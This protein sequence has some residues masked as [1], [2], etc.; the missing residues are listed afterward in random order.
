MR[1]KYIYISSVATIL[2]ASNI[3]AY[4]L[5]Q[6][7]TQE[8]V[9]NNQVRYIDNKLKNQQNNQKTKTMEQINAEEGISAEQIVVKITD[10]GYVTSHGDHFHFY[11][12]KVPFDAI[13]S[14]ELVMKDSNYQFNEAHV[15]NNI[16]DGYIIKVDGK[17]YA[18]LKPNSVQKNIRSKAEIEEQVA[19]GTR[20]AKEKSNNKV[21]STN[22][23]KNRN[24]SKQTHFRQ[25]SH[26]GRYTTDDGYVFNP[27]DVIDDFGDAYLVPHG[28]HFHYIPKKDLSP[29][30]LAA[31]QNFWM[32]KS[33]KENSQIFHNATL[34]GP[35]ISNNTNSIHNQLSIHTSSPESNSY[36][37]K[38]FNELLTQ[39][40]SQSLDQRHTEEDG[41]VFEPTQVTGVNNFG[42]II[43]HGDHF[44]IIPHHKLSALEITLA[45]RHLA[46]RPNISSIP[47]P[48]VSHSISQNMPLPQAPSK[49]K[50]HYL[51]NREITPYGQGLDGRTYTTSD[52]YQ[53]NK[54]SILSVDKLGITVKH[55]DHLHYIGLGELEQSELNHVNEWLKEN[56]EVGFTP[57]VSNPK[58]ILLK[59]KFDISKVTRKK[60]HNG[61]IGYILTINNKEYYYDRGELDLT[62]IAF[63]EQELM[64]KNED[65]YIFDIVDSTIQPRLAVAI[66]SLPMHAGN[67]TY[68]TGESFIIPHIDHIHVV[69]YS[70]L[71]NDQIATIKYVMQ[72][73]E[74]RPEVW[75]NPEHDDKSTVIEN[76][77]PTDKR[78]GLQNWQI[79]HN[80]DEI[81]KAKSAGRYT[82]S[83]GYIF[84]P[85]DVLTKGVFVWS[86]QSFSIPR[87]DGKS[88]RTIR[89]EDLSEVEWNKVQELL[90]SKETTETKE[91]AKEPE[92]S[93]ISEIKEPTTTSSEQNLENTKNVTLP[94]TEETSLQNIDKSSEEYQANTKITEPTS[95]NTTL[96]ERDPFLVGLPDYGIDDNTLLNNINQ[97]SQIAKRDRNFLIFVPE[98]VKFYD[99]NGKLV[100][101]DIVT[102]QRIN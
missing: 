32:S 67:A 91:L 4:Y 54:Q 3:G 81:D 56:E 71:S 58:P 33:G 74:V 47:R 13:I 66:S 65:N 17:Y 24:D 79:V 53:F 34:P 10:K 5:G 89:K 86:N 9:Q 40:H 42:Y 8:T 12:G 94:S 7:H 45:D 59:P 88:L 44:H 18:Y 72:H 92:I 29:G 38:S 76:V 60:I 14:E 31:A 21:T 73:P 35:S 102:L 98:G 80:N 55:D 49:S 63:V 43:P 96:P 46:G 87:L 25:S 11:N 52:H 2:I 16:Q 30:E 26:Q 95:E 22:G 100:L 62:Q 28:D 93:T 1:K 36:Q 27:T 77:T 61:K 64:L 90:K 68:D 70:W 85:K 101:Y 57:T 6:H 41:L 20:E 50:K 75:S 84:D 97:I 78:D 83:D 39:L 23:H 51:G 99:E 69:P 15:I 37:N 82:E 19:I 48:N